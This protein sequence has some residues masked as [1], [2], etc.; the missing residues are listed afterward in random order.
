MAHCRGRGAVW[1]WTMSF[2]GVNDAVSVADEASTLNLGSSNF[3]VMMLGSAMYNALG[4]GAA[5]PLQQVQCDIVAQKHGCK[6]FYLSVGGQLQHQ[7]ARDPWRHRQRGAHPA[8]RHPGD[9]GRVGAP[10]RHQRRGHAAPLR[11]RHPVASRAQTGTITVSANALRIGGNT[12]GRVLQRHDRRGAGLHRA[13]TA[14]E[15]QTDMNTPV[16]RRRGHDGAGA[17]AGRCPRAAAGGHHPDHAAAEQQRERHLPLRHHRRH[18]LCGDAQ[19][20]HHHRW[21]RAHATSAA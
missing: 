9:R 2:D 1:Q 5:A 16:A 17:A 4:G 11:Q 12:T 6:E 3:T 13:L 14:A 20:L 19:H 15:I 18:G 7:S 10:G 8:G 21:A